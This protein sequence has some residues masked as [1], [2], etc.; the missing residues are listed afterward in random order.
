MLEA[1]RRVQP[2][3]TPKENHGVACRNYTAWGCRPGRSWH[4]DHGMSETGGG[5]CEY[6]E[7][8]GSSGTGTAKSPLSQ[9]ERATSPP[10][11]IERSWGELVLRNPNDD[12]QILSGD[13]RRR[14]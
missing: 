11:R 8:I 14:R 6:M 5:M 9:A 3:P 2:H 13:R 10:R 12:S 4:A 1:G 7:T